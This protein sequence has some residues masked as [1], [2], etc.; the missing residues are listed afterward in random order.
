MIRL[1]EMYA[2]EAEGVSEK[3]IFDYQWGVFKKRYKI[4]EYLLPI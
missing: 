4:S 2:S 1:F 3:Y